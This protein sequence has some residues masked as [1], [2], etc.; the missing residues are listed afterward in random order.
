MSSLLTSAL[1]CSKTIA[2]CTVPL[3][4]VCDGT[5]APRC[6]AQEACTLDPKT[7]T[8]VCQKACTKACGTNQECY[9]ATPTDPECRNVETFDSGALAF[10]G[11]TTPITLY[12]PYSF[13]SSTD[14]G[15]PFLAGASIEVQAS[16]AATVGFDKF[17]EKFQATTFLQTSPALSSLTL[18][19]VWGTGTIPVGW[20]P[21]NDAIQ[22]EVAGPAGAA[23]CDA[24]DGSGHFDI[25]REV[26][27]AVVGTSSQSL[28]ISVTRKRVETKKDAKTKGAL[29]TATVQPVGFL[30][31]T[32]M[33]TESASF[34]GCVGGETMCGDHCAS[35]ESSSTDCGICGNV[36]KNGAYCSGGKCYGGTTPPGCSA[37]LT[38]CNGVC[39][40]T[41]TD[42][43][44]C[45]LCNSPCTGAL[46]CVGGTCQ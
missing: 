24:N 10:S 32:T 19:Q 15:A 28:V 20:A 36:C 25:P 26:V 35:L 27:S 30:Q 18:A 7:C 2:G 22:V 38:L 42:N 33:S 5:T 34:V 11:T 12:P 43:A 37:G 3:T 9:F 39:V 41:Q 45:G 1:H 21:G 8:P 40:D 44:N 31:L 13:A 6:G 29:T 14:N 17:D 16:G 23:T 4:A 46:S